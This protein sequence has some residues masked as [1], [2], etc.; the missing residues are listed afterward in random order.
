MNTIERRKLQTIYTVVVRDDQRAIV[1]R[2]D[3]ANSL[4]ALL[5]AAADAN[6]KHGLALAATAAGLDIEVMQ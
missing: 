4:A 2:Q 6:I 1:H 5:N 3:L